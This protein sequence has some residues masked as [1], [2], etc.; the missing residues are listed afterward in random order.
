MLDLQKNR[1]GAR[2]FLLLR[3]KELVDNAGKRMN[4]TSILCICGDHFY[5]F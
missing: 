1:R 2:G 3:H 4:L 5:G